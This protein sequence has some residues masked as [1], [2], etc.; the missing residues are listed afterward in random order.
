MTDRVTADAVLAAAERVVEEE[1]FAAL[2]V[3][4]I[5]TEL[6]VSR[7]VVYTH[8]GGMDGLL[9][10]LHVRT[11][12][13]L[14]SRVAALEEEPGTVA[15]VLAAGRVYVD[16]ARRRPRLFELAFGRPVPGYEPDEV[17]LAAARSSFGPIIAAA[18]AWLAASGVTADQAEE[19]ELARVFWATA[20]GHVT[21]ELAGHAEPATTDRLV[22]RALRALLAGWAEPA[23]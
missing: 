11:A 14:G 10:A 7:Q 20:H 22:D 21:I 18:R 4:R 15:H 23:S 6:G 17:A 13:D 19:V 16:E 5:G 12:G 8:F 2:S 3:R 1:G 9:E